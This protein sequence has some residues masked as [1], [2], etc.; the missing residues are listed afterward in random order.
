MKNVKIKKK[1]KMLLEESKGIG[2]VQ[3]KTLRQTGNW[4]AREWIFSEKMQNLNYRYIRHQ[5]QK[6]SYYRII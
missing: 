3:T 4:E 2:V 5:P 6:H 1:C